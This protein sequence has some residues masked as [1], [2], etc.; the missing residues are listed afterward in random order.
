MKLKCDKSD[1]CPALFCNHKGKHDHIAQCDKPCPRVAGARCVPVEDDKMPTSTEK[2]AEAIFDWMDGL[3]GEWVHSP[4]EFLP[5]NVCCDF[6]GHTEFKNGIAG[7]IE[8]YMAAMPPVDPG[9]CDGYKKLFGF[10]WPGCP[11]A[12]HEAYPVCTCSPERRDDGCPVHK[13]AQA[14]ADNLV[15][16]VE[17]ICKEFD[18]RLEEV[19]LPFAR[20]E[21]AKAL[22]EAEIPQPT[23][24]PEPTRQIQPGEPPPKCLCGIGRGA[25]WCPIH[26][27]V[28]GGLVK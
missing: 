26:G 9:C 1:E 12:D 24:H 16:R 14:D 23:V 20:L 28:T 11:E 3:K 8:K 2:L 15:K 18:D 13:A 21:L 6:A 27:V 22:A 25:I 10:H 17:E 4:T 7:I 5:A 19:G